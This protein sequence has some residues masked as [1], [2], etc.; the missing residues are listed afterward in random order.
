MSIGTQCRRVTNIVC[1]YLKKLE[2]NLNQPPAEEKETVV[3][4]H[5]RKYHKA[6]KMNILCGD[7]L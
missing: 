4:I 3:K 2:K 7:H 1:N 6:I 5:R